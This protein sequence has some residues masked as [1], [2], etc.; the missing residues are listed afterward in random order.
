[1]LCRDSSSI[2][3]CYGQRDIDPSLDNQKSDDVHLSN[4]ISVYA[5][6]RS[7]VEKFELSYFERSTIESRLDWW[8]AANLSMALPSWDCFPF[9]ARTKTARCAAVLLAI[10]LL[11]LVPF[12]HLISN[13]VHDG[14]Q[15]QSVQQQ[16]LWVQFPTDP[17]SVDLRY[18]LTLTPS[19]V[20]DWLA[21]HNPDS[22]T[23]RLD[24]QTLIPTAQLSSRKVNVQA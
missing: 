9:K 20:S 12:I 21:T 6:S 3:K 4:V 16:G 23:L 11:T 7:V 2:T 13:A 17:S 15:A 19:N 1:M 10:V 14:A 5:V 18:Q 8:K 24:N 22:H